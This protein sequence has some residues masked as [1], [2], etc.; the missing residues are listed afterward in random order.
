MA[1]DNQDNVRLMAKY[2][3]LVAQITVALLLAVYGG[4]WLDNL[5]GS[6]QPYITIALVFLALGTSF[7]GVYKQVSE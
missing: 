3:G 6:P 1:D 5:V 4:Q 2:G 7:Y